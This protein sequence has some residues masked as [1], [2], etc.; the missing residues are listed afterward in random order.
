MIFSKLLFFKTIEAILL[1][2]LI[3]Q[4]NGNIRS[5]NILLAQCINEDISH[6]SHIKILISRLKMPSFSM[7]LPS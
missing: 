2:F 1:L 4:T 5:L 6:I 7:N 3:N